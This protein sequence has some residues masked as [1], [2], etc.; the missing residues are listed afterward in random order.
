MADNNILSN[1]RIAKNTLVLYVRTI[2]ILIISLY[3]SR[4]ILNTL[5]VVDFGINNVVGGLVSM[6]SV[7]SSS[8]CSSVS[9]YITYE[10]GT[11]NYARLKTIFR[12]SINI[13]LGIAIV[14]LIIGSLAGSW[15]L[16]Y[17]MS[18]PENRLYAANWVL[19]C[20]LLSFVVNI[21]NVPYTSCIIS[22]ERMDAFAYI[23]IAETVLKLLIAYAIMIST[24][25]KLITYTVLYLCL[26]VIIF[27]TYFIYCKLHFEECSYKIEIDWPVLKEMTQ[28][29]G[30]NFFG[31]TAYM[32]NTQ[33]VNML[34]NIFFGVQINA[35]RAIG[36]QV[37][38][39]ILQFVNNFTTA[40]NPQITKSYAAGN[41]E[42]LHKLI[43]LGSKYSYFLL[44]IFTVPIYVEADTV[45]KLWL[46][47]VPDYSVIFLRLIILTSYVTILG[48][49]SFTA[50]MATGKVKSYQLVMTL[51]G[52]LVFPLSWILYKLGIDVESTYYVYI[53]IYGILIFIRLYYLKILVQMP[54]INF[55]K[56]VLVKVLL[57]SI[58]AF[59]IPFVFIHFY[60]PTMFRLLCTCLISII[61]N[62][63]LI[64]SLGLSSNERIFLI[65]KIKQKIEKKGYVS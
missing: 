16:N 29:A 33:G 10:L 40:V 8:L 6:F 21:L 63:F 14:V 3:T 54:P 65:S 47:T 13:Q 41:I 51:V 22:H 27:I 43:C 20:S 28:F 2:V 59:F 61:S 31:N 38:G 56:Y 58:P 39:A 5:G 11:G 37:Q 26:S 30:W 34:I 53:I 12:T 44:L 15:F 64:Y 17:K 24:F 52:C 46:K 45:L 23:T 19:Y 60:Q 50:V 1:K 57:L 18:I 49:T 9:R 55:I 25:D 32:L 48:N 4:V 36:V 62:I 35:A 42:Y 7:I